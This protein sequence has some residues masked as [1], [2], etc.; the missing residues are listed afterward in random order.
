[1]LYMVALGF[2]KVTCCLIGNYIGGGKHEH[3]EKVYR[4]SFTASVALFLM[5]SLSVGVF[6][7]QIVAIFSSDPVVRDLTAHCLLL[8]SVCYV[9]DGTQNYLQGPI[10]A[11]G[12]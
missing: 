11:L 6:R 1:M 3:A 12:F 5:V 8:L 4:V 10:R 9:F 2:Q 7:A